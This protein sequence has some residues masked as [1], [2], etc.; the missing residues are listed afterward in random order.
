MRLA[1]IVP[2]M[3]L[4]QPRKDAIMY[5]NIRLSYKISLGFAAI[6][7]LAIA[8]GTIALWN[9]KRV[10]ELSDKL[11]REYVP[12]VAVANNIEHYSLE[13]MFEMR[14]YGL[15]REKAYLDAGNENLE[16]VKKHL[17]IAEQLSARSPDL[18]TFKEEVGLAQA[19][20]NEYE[21]IVSQ[22]VAGNVKIANLRKAMDSAAGNF[23]KNAREY[24]VSQRKQMEHEIEGSESHEKLLARMG[25]LNLINDVIESGNSIRIANFKFQAVGDPKFI[26]GA[27]KKFPEIGAKLEEIKSGT[28]LELNKRQLD[29]IGA[30]AG[31][32]KK[33]MRDFLANWRSLREI[34]KKRGK[35][36]NNVA[37]L[38]RKAVLAG[39]ERAKEAAT[40][41]TTA[42]S[43]A[44]LIMSIGLVT[45]LLLGIGMA[46][47]IVRS[48]TKPI[49]LIVD[50]LAEGAGLVAS[51]ANQVSSSSQQLATG[52]SEQAASIEET[53]SSL[54]EM[55]SMTKQNAEN[56]GQA[57][58]LM[59]ECS[60]VVV[61]AKQSMEKLNASMF[62][63]TKA[64]EETSMIIKTIDEIAFQTN[65]LALN[66]AVEAA[67]AGEVGAGFAVVADEV[68]NLAM[69]SAEAAK[70]TANLIEGTMKKIKDRSEL[71]EETSVDFSQVARS[72]GKISELIAE[73]S[74]AT[75]EQAQGIEQVN[76][77]VNEI[78]KVVQTNA[79]TAE[80][81]AS[82]AEEMN[83]QAENMKSCVGE[84]VSIV[85]GSWNGNVEERKSQ[86]ATNRKSTTQSLALARF[87]QRRIVSNSVKSN[88]A[89]G[90]SKTFQPKDAESLSPL[91]DD[92]GMVDF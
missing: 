66:A 17:E 21:Q 4:L 83:A 5:K 27:M 56:A 37:Q 6:L 78:S 10:G 8:L 41:A 73:I 68:R 79:A 80:E 88:K 85:D 74:A 48:I 76:K 34:N 13:T 18:V 19:K 20:A 51:E 67:R 38:A 91:G 70:N 26:D 90:T 39:M 60:R 71:V 63:I 12:E 40:T 22:T 65:L 25:K 11:D 50:G 30:A 77:A 75:N 54:E 53:S 72:S 81:S 31:L 35:T 23:M 52:A 44:S 14:G 7:F 92:D 3:N 46:F 55:S 86:D 59:A 33:A 36:G 47:I 28:V 89:N 9:M 42:L 87:E 61:K 49:R 45:V 1:P 16:E 32:Y 69:R 64:S 29:E 2:G 24:E 43:A 82:A 15:T 84:L 58:K 62:K 57:K